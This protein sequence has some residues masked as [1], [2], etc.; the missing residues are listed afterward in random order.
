MVEDESAS[1]KVLAP[2]SLRFVVKTS[3]R[4]VVERRPFDVQFITMVLKRLVF[5]WAATKSS[6]KG[7]R[8]L[9]SGC[10]PGKCRCFRCNWKCIHFQ[11]FS[12]AKHPVNLP[13][14]IHLKPDNQDAYLATSPV[15]LRWLCDSTRTGCARRTKLFVCGANKQ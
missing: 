7:G 12:L 4:H 9:E 2:I 6:R 10:A 15:V 5:I 3:L 8:T 13:V 11:K 14:N 1:D